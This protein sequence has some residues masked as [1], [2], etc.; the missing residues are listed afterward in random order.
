MLYG[1]G[2]V[3]CCD[4]VCYF[5]FFQWRPSWKTGRWRVIILR[6]VIKDLRTHSHTNPM[7]LYSSPSHI[8]LPALSSTHLTVCPAIWGHFPP[9]FVS[10]LS[11]PYPLP[12]YL[13]LRRVWTVNFLLSMMCRVSGECCLLLWAWQLLLS[14]PFPVTCEALSVSLWEH[15]N[16]FWT[17]IS[18][19]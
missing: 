13:L 1:R 12:L 9:P 3:R 6:G 14:S 7:L 5:F 18:V 11:S 2:F 16:C 17:P 19:H 10:S 4:T 8:S 15:V